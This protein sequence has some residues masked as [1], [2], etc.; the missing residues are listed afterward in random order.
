MPSRPKATG[1]LIFDQKKKICPWIEVMPLLR[2]NRLRQEQRG[3]STL[4]RHLSREP[5]R[6][7][8]VTA[9]STY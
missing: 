2:R 6:G 5:H 9:A 1:D 8:R 7:S 3:T 4:S